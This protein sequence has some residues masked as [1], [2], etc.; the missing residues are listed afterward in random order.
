MDEIILLITKTYGLAAVIMLSPFIGLV[1][2][3]RHNVQLQK[4]KDAQNAKHEEAMKVLQDSLNKV[5]ESRVADAKVMSDKMLTV[6]EIQSSANKEVSM[7]LDQVRE[8]LMKMA[9]SR[10]T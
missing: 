5:Q 6:V 3:W 1:V 8:L 4:E 9:T 2:V 7:T 10:R